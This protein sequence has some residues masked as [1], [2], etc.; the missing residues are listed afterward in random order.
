MQKLDFV[1]GLEEIARQLRSDEIN[2]IFETGLSNPQANFDYSPIS[3]ILFSSKSNYDRTIAI[4]DYKILLQ[5]LGADPI[6]TDNNLSALSR[7]IGTHQ[8]NILTIKIIN[9]LFRLHSTIVMLRDI[10]KEVLLN[11]ILDRNPD[12]TLNDGVIVFHVMIDNEGL[13]PDSYIKILDGLNDLIKILNRIHKTETESEKTEIILLDS[14]SG[15]NLGIKT[16]VDTAKSLFLIFKEI[17]DFIANH[18]FYKLKKQNEVLMESLTVRQNLNQMMQE[19]VITADEFKEYS[20]V[21][22]SRTDSLIAMKVLPKELLEVRMY[23]DNKL[24]LKEFEEF[25]LLNKGDKGQ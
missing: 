21:I 14:G 19:G 1:K 4:E 23:I 11:P 10:G 20:H 22:K 8:G 5:K 13:S 16:T 6:Y 17:W 18:K 2:Q 25:K 3:P 24:V 7:T 15:T 12:Q 9:E